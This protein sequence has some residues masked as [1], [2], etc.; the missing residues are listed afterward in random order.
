MIIEATRQTFVV[1]RYFVVLGVFGV[2]NVVV[3]AV[4]SKLD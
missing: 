2:P 3:D 1:V 4:G